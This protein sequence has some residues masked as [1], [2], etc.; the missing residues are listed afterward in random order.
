MTQTTLFPS[1]TGIARTS[2]VL[3]PLFLI[4]LPSFPHLTFSFLPLLSFFFPIYFRFLSFLLPPSFP[5]LLSPPASSYLL[6]PC[7]ISFPS[8]LFHFLPCLLPL[9]SAFSFFPSF[10][11]FYWIL[12]SDLESVN[13]GGSDLNSVHLNLMGDRQCEKY[14]NTSKI[15]RY[16]VTSLKFQF[17]QD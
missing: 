12:N 1:H 9:P 7:P 6:L 8:I 14:R 5:C 10:K 16:M 15:S 4:S 11:V 17:L 3:I 2:I 13:E